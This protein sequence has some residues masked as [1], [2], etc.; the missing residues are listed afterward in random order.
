MSKAQR[1][2]NSKIG[3]LY[4]VASGNALQGVFWNDPKIATADNGSP[5]AALLEQAEREISEYLEGKR[6]IFRMPLEAEGTEF[7]KR[8]WHRLSRIPYGET[9][10]YKQIAIELDDANAS[11]AVGTANGRNPIS[12]IIPCHR[13]ISSDGSL[14][15]YAGGLH[16][17]EMLL[18][19]EKKGSLE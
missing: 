8:V 6:K 7:Q 11:R 14:G 13:V 16:I 5:E 4:L 17:K 15:G 1:K 9:R 18:A 2:M 10:S 3:P 12:I 19:L